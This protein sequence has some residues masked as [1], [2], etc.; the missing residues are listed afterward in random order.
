MATTARKK[1]APKKRAAPVVAARTAVAP[2]EYN[3]HPFVQATLGERALK[4]S[5]AHPDGSQFFVGQTGD[6]EGR[7]GVALCEAKPDGTLVKHFGSRAQLT[8][9]LDAHA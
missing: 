7:V 9:I 6:D 5:R 8:A 1:A 3:M 2:I 4:V